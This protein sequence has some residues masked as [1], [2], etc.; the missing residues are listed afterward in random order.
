[1]DI[2]QIIDLCFKSFGSIGIFVAIQQL[3][4]TKKRRIVEM[5]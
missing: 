2:A 3:Y 1:M 4:E 5:Y